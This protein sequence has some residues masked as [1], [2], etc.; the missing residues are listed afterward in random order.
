MQLLLVETKTC[1]VTTQLA[2]VFPAGLARA[3]WE[4]FADHVNS[5]S[6]ESMKGN[7]FGTHVLN[8]SV[9]FT[10][11]GF[12]LPRHTASNNIELDCNV[13]T[14]E[15]AHVK[16]LDYHS[17][18]T[19][20]LNQIQGYLEDDMTG[21]R[22]FSGDCVDLP[23]ANHSVCGCRVSQCGS[24]SLTADALMW[25]TGADIA[26]VNSGSIRGSLQEGR[27]TRD[28]LLQMLPFM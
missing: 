8:V 28:S 1:Q 15:A 16:I 5:H 18:M 19:T 3:I 7:A 12:V 22:S 2:T 23:G 25:Y 13:A 4:Y 6:D 10:E 20:Y 14:D 17:S 24:G 26:M 11:D 27:V 9:G 21:E